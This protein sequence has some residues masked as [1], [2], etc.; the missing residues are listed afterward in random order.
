MMKRF[1]IQRGGMR[2]FA[3]AVM[4]LAVVALFVS[5]ALALSDKEYLRMKKECPAFAKADRELGQ[6]WKEAQKALG[7]GDFEKLKKQQ[8]NWIASG[9]DD[10]AE[11]LID[12]GEDHDEAYAAATMERVR[13]LRKIVDA[14]KKSSGG[15]KAVKHVT[16]SNFYAIYE[17]RDGV[18]F[19]SHGRGNKM[20][21]EFF[22][23]DF[24]WE[25]DGVINGQKIDLRD[26]KGG[27]MTLVLS[28]QRKDGLITVITVKG[29]GKLS[30]LDGT[31]NAYEGHM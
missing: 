21:I 9:R 17:R 27:R 15:S 31:Y 14:A 25:G 8:Q 11:E 24:T 1:R 4:V 10:V 20:R 6:V 30:R 5:S 23:G 26:G 18:Y 12:D 3:V 7:K 19:E 16:D 13:E 2:P 28:K 22:D 29:N